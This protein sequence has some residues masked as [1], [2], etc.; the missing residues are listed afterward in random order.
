M[1]RNSLHLLGA[2][3]LLLGMAHAQVCA[4]NEHPIHLVLANGTEA[5]V[6]QG[7]GDTY[8]QFA[9]EGVYL[10]FHPSTPS[11]TYYVHVTDVIGDPADDVVLSANDPMDR[12]VTVQNDNGVIS[13]SLPFTNNPN[14]AVFGLGLGGVGQSLRLAPFQ[15]A[16]HS[17]CEFGVQMGDT[18]DLSMGPAWPYTIRGGF[19]QQ[20]G[21]CSVFSYGV[22]RIGDALGS[23][24][25][26]TVFNDSDHDTAIDQTEAGVPGLTVQLV[27]VN[28][29]LTTTA[30][31]SG[32]YSF[33]DVPAGS[34]SLE[35]VTS[36]AYVPSGAASKGLEVCGCGAVTGQD[37]GVN[38]AVL[39]CDP[40]PSA[41]W[42][43][44]HGLQLVQQYGILATLPALHL[45]NMCGQQVAPGSLLNFRWYLTFTNSWNM[46]YR[47]SS[48]LLVMHCNV[49]TGLV[50]PM[51]VVNDPALGQIMVGDLMANAIASLAAHPFTPP[52]S[53][54]RA[55]QSRMRNALFRA[56]KNQNWL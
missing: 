38:L 18:W 13:L 50:D 12:F 11:G 31:A 44:N 36:G 42:R 6:L 17:P 35:L 51:C 26:G 41:F 32:H 1:I 47:L 34:Y 2:T 16:P 49:M 56:N 5:P 25:S 33:A 37:F 52:C 48:E 14:T 15:S 3:S 23:D 29:T 53:A 55:E 9:D 24:I 20:L 21:R 4:A 39:T 30:D 22:F 7:L 54:H 27:G 10:A 43:H 45:V 40:R 19:N 8:W 28:G 46:A